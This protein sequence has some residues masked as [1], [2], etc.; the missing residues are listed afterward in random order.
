MSDL[1]LP[2]PYCLLPVPFAVQTGGSPGKH[3]KI[4]P[5][6]P[7]RAK[8]DSPGGKLFL[9]SYLPISNGN[10]AT[11]ETESPDPGFLPDPGDSAAWFQKKES[12]WDTC[13][14]PHPLAMA[15]W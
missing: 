14:F 3:P 15:L 10:R 9:H 4:S 7:G 1:F 8:K 11:G 6:T 2:V 13:I 12:F 5:E